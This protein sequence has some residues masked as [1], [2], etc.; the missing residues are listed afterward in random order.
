MSF[1][2][3]SRTGRLIGL[4][5]FCLAIHWA[6]PAFAQNAR[7]AVKKFR[8][9]QAAQK[10]QMIKQLQSQ[11]SVA[12]KTSSQ[13]EAELANVTP[14]L[15]SA[16]SRLR[17][18]QDEVARKEKQRVEATQRLRTL[19]E[20]LLAA[21]PPE[22][23]S[24]KVETQLLNAQKSLHAEVHRILSLPEHAIE[25]RTA[26]LSHEYLKLSESQKSR[27]KADKQYSQQTENIN[28]LK[29]QIKKGH[30]QLFE[31]NPEWK[32]LEATR[33]GII[34]EQK[35]ANEDFKNA[36]IEVARN[37]KKVRSAQAALLS[38]KQVIQAT[39]SQLNI[40]GADVSP[41]K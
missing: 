35:A 4:F 12:Q 31:A 28:V 34:E 16:E 27:L 23:P 21:Q 40:L 14:S 37:L 30:R 33:D 15:S 8:A 24:A 25:D 32:K 13:A 10:Q 20:K 1:F 18:I 6:S 17:T 19:E 39:S 26:H 38:A 22:S 2:S 29:E 11:L 41:Q 9:M 7:G 36:K 3:H 5:L